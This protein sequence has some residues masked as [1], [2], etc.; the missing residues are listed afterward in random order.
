[1]VKHPQQTEGIGIESKLPAG[2]HHAGDLSVKGQFSKADPAYS[3]IPHESAGSSTAM[4]AVMLSHLEFRFFL[5]FFKKTLSG[6]TISSALNLNP[7]ESL[8]FPIS[9]LSGFLTTIAF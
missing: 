1:M 3:K 7:I 6:Q 5:G 2:L 4:T 9:G 8:E